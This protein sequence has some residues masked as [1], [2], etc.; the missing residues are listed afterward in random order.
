MLCCCAWQIGQSGSDSWSIP[1][2]INPALASRRAGS[3]LELIPDGSPCS[4][5]RCFPQPPCTAVLSCICVPIGQKRSCGSTRLERGLP[6]R[7]PPVEMAPSLQRST[8]GLMQTSDSKFDL[9][10]ADTRVRGRLSRWM[11]V[12]GSAC[13]RRKAGQAVAG[14]PRCAPIGVSWRRDTEKESCEDRVGRRRGLRAAGRRK[15]EE[16]QRRR[17][18]IHSEEERGGMLLEGLCA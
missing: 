6:A 10:K 12:L 8:A 3:P 5:A 7:L 4:A 17:A 2:V 18:F 14:I 9:A 13:N 11:L 1:Q 16:E 15:Q